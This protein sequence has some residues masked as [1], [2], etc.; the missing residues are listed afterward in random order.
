MRRICTG[1]RIACLARGQFPAH[2]EGRR[3]ARTRRSHRRAA[4][5]LGAELV[6]VHAPFDLDDIA[7]RL[8]KILG[9]ESYALHRAYIENEALPIDPWVR[10]RVLGGKEIS[11]ADYLG[12][13]A[14]M[15]NTRAESARGCAGTT[16]C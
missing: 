9:A 6:D 8:G 12:N 13:L 3:R 11:A 1:M 10:K 16:R 2:I 7:A 15:R 4:L 5:S 14:A